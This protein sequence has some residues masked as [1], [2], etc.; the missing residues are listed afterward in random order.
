MQAYRQVVEG[1]DFKSLLRRFWT[2][3]PA[4]PEEIETLND[5]RRVNFPL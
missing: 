2:F 1:L 4:T 3:V 5:C